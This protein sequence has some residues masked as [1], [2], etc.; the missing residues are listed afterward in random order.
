MTLIQCENLN[1]SYE[2]SVVLKDVNF[3]V[4]E[5]DYICIVGENGSGKSTLIKGLLGIKAPKSG[6][7]KFGQGMKQNQIGYLP[8]QTSIQKDFPASVF[9]VVLSGCLSKRGLKPFFSKN[10]KSIAIENMRKL[11]IENLIKKS[12]ADLS[13][14][15]QQR[16]LLARALCATE[17]ILLLDEPVTGLDPVVTAELYDLIKKLNKENNIT[18]IMV[19]H[20]INSAIENADKILH[21]DG[22]VLFYGSTEEY[23]NSD[24]SNKFIGGVTGA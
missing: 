13:G 1:M 9:E 6:K 18:I 16:V 24:A 19:S 15:Q 8:Q 22:R 12:Y 14:G 4:N 10:E 23:R 20:D 7:I 3:E 2:N 5:G 11:G 17:K 21:I